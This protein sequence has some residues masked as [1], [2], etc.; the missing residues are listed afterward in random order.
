[1]SEVE[2]EWRILLKK[3]VLKYLNLDGDMGQE[4][5]TEEQLDMFEVGDDGCRECFV[6]GVTG[7]NTV[8][9]IGMFGTDDYYFLYHKF[10]PS[11]SNYAPGS[12]F[13]IWYQIGDE[14]SEW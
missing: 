12:T 9:D 6:E 5:P 4:Y 14:N 11:Q 1:M 7:S 8:M 2:P 13:S 10:V 3:D